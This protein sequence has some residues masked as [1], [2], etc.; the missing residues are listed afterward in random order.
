MLLVL[1]NRYFTTTRAG[2]G[3]SLRCGS[4]VEGKSDVAFLYVM[5]NKDVISRGEVTDFL[6]RTFAAGG[7]KVRK[8][9]RHKIY[10]LKQG[11]EIAY[12]AVCGGIIL[13]SDS[14]LYIE[15]GLKQFDLEEAGEGV[16]PHY[17]NLNKYFSAG[18]GINILLNTGAFTELMPLYIQVKKVFPHVDITRFFKWGALDGDSAAR[19]FV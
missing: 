1:D 16:K 7:E 5:D 18:A 10:T 8:Y 4:R 2:E 11:K 9:D 13:L 6:N 17:Q 14:D 12:F 3:T 19:G 15:D